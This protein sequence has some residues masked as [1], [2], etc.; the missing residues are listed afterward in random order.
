MRILVKKWG[1]RASVRITAS[2]MEA[3]KLEINAPVEVRE[4]GGRI[5]IEPIRNPEYDLDELLVGIPSDNIY[6]GMD[7]GA[8][9]L[10]TKTD[11]GALST[12]DGLVA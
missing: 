7:F 8:L 2:I 9:I 4:A 5:V 12:K 3:A 6:E 11:N 1:N 10:K